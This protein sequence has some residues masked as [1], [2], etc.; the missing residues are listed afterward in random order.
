M[1]CMARECIYPVVCVRDNGMYQCSA[2]LLV[3]V[4]IIHCRYIH[5][6][7]SQDKE[8]GVALITAALL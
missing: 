8:G 7:G 6:N 5:V 1:S 4:R 3:G 2:S